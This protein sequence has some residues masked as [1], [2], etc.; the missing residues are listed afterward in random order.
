MTPRA[1]GGRLVE[2]GARPDLL[3]V[4]LGVVFAVLGWFLA[5]NI[6]EAIAILLATA[7]LGGVA[8]VFLESATLRI[9]VIAFL[10]GFNC[11]KLAGGV[12][13]ELWK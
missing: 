2:G 12:Y 13:L 3:P 4:G 7:V 5:E 6:G 8:L 1:H 11:G 9:V 10:C